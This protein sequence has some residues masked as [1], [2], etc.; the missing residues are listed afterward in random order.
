[1]RPSF[2]KQSQVLKKKKERSD[3]DTIINTGGQLST[4]DET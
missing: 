4:P 1:M 2:K 3:N